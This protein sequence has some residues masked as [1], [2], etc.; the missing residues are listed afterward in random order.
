M[1]KVALKG[2]GARK[3]RTA[4]TGFAVVIGVAFVVGTLVFTDTINES[5]KN[6]FE[7]VQ[8]GVEHMARAREY[9]GLDTRHPWTEPGRLDGEQRLGIRADVAGEGGAS[10]PRRQGRTNRRS[11]QTVDCGDAGTG[12]SRR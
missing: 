11:T 2:L 1:L 5:F 9:P 10:C 12:R 8:K 7:R 4:L 6:L 3:L